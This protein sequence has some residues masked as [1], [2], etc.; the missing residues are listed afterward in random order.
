M[1]VRIAVEFEA[2][3]DAWFGDAKALYHARSQEQR[4]VT[5]PD[6]FRPFP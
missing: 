3:Y 1:E 5:R 2:R 4:L 6:R